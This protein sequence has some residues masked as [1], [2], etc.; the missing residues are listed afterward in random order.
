ML[1]VV[2]STISLGEPRHMTP[3]LRQDGM[4]LCI[5]WSDGFIYLSC[6]STQEMNK[7]TLLEPKSVSCQLDEKQ[8][9]DPVPLPASTCH[10][11]PHFPAIIKD[12]CRC[13]PR[14]GD[15]DR[16]QDSPPIGREFRNN[17]LHI[18]LRERMTRE[19][20]DF[21]YD[22]FHDS[23]RLTSNRDRPPP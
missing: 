12:G 4:Q 1:A 21:I 6:I 20:I 15:V 13:R 14:S 19:S 7:R 5:N 17:L 2:R 8:V 9:E 23:N 22:D 10:R 3:C 16:S 11:K 18:A